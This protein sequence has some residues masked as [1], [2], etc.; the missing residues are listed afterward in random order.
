MSAATIIMLAVGVWIVALVLAV[1]LCDMAASADERAERARVDA[2][3]K[4]SNVRKLRP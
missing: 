3:E 2:Q 1:A 4:A